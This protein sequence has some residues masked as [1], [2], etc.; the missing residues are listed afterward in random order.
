MW[1]GIL[2]EISKEFGVSISF[3]AAEGS[4]TFFS[5]PIRESKGNI[6][7]SSKEMYT[8]NKMRH[9]FL[10]EWKPKIVVIAAKWDL[11]KGIQKTKDLIEFLGAL[12][13]KVLLI[14]QPPKLFFGDKNTPQYLSHMNIVPEINIKKYVPKHDSLSYNNG[15]VLIRR[16]SEKYA[17]CKFI[18]TADIFLKEN[19][20]WVL[21][22]PDVLY[23]D[24]D[25]LSYKGTLKA[26]N[27]IKQSMAYYIKI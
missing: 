15:L 26:K 23:I 4:P 20:V 12:G 8:F 11:I 19:E 9:H 7:F 2:D 5:I 27:R 16:I 21:D 18:A 6:F 10:K 22:G 17:Y 1:A 25:H 3:Y 14:E 24:N 13:S